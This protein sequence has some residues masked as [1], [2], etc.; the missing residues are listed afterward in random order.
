MQPEA[1]LLLMDF[2][3]VQ[4]ERAEHYSAFHAAFKAFLTSRLEAAYQTQVQATTR[5][6]SACSLRVR[7]IS[8]KL[9]QVDRSSNSR[10]PCRLPRAMRASTCCRPSL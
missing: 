7:E 10:S 9:A 3:Q 5:A 2:M 4:Q 6:F 1:P 8:D